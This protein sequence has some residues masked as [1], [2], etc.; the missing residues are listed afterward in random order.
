MAKL[1]SIPV[2]GTPGLRL[3]NAY[4]PLRTLIREIISRH[5][6]YLKRELPLIEGSLADIARIQA[7]DCSETAAALLPIFS[8]F[9]RELEAHM[10][11][12][13]V[14]LFPLIERLE[15]AVTAGQ[16]APHNTFGPLSNA[17]QFM[18]EDHHFENKL[19][20]RMAEISGGFAGSSFAGVM[21]HL[22]TMRLDLEEHVRKEDESL[23]PAAI[24]LEQ[25]RL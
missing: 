11:R 21:E 20:G 16:P 17:I 3:E 10:R 6:E 4:A 25:G 24:R 13:E 8:R 12:E 19:L 23:F 5:H 2:V 14:I 1:L 18:N 15:R 9:R 7:D 22:R